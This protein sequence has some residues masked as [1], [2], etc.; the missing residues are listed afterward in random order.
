[1]HVNGGVAEAQTPIHLSVCPAGGR[2]RAEADKIALLVPPDVRAVLRERSER[3]F[4][5]TEV[6]D[7]GTVGAYEE[8]SPSCADL[9]EKS[10]A[11]KRARVVNSYAE[12]LRAGLLVVLAPF[13]RVQKAVRLETA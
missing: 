1:M 10:D 12:Y 2:Q 8:Y 4:L 11:Y 6:L 5:V 7:N 9:D 3:A 13:P